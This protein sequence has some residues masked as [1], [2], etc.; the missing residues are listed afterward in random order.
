QLR[1]FRNDYADR[2]ATL[3]VRLTGTRS[4]R[5]AIGAR[6]TLETEQLRVTRIVQAGSGFISQHAKELLFGL[7]RSKE[8]RKAT[9]VWPSGLTQTLSDLSP[10]QRVWI[11]EGRAVVRSEPFEKPSVPTPVR[12]PAVH[13]AEAA[14]AGT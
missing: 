3:A 13:T 6:V 1:L 10:G 11:E 2:G 8:I 12:P 4:N 9:I 7:G 5:D 14:A